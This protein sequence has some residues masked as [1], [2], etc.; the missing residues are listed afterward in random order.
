MTLSASDIFNNNGIRQEIEGDGF[1]AL[2]ENYCETQ[3]IRL[4]AKYKF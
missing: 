1:D 3:V 2:Y 4:G